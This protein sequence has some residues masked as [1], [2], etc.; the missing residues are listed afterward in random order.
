MIS[1]ADVMYYDAFERLKL[2]LIDLQSLRGSLVGFSS[3]HVQVKGYI[4]LKMKFKLK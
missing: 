2:D 4:T 1:L 3:E